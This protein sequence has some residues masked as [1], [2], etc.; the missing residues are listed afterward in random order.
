MPLA[1]WRIAT[2]PMCIRAG[3]IDMAKRSNPFERPDS[4]YL[5]AAQGWLELGLHL[6]ANAELE[7]ITPQLRTH[8]DVLDLRWQIY[9]REKQWTG[10]VDIARTL[11]RLAPRRATSW[12]HYSYSL[13]EL[14]RT[15]EALDNLLPVVN[16]FPGV[17][18]IPYN[19]ACYCSQLRRFA[20]ARQWLD[21]A[22]AIDGDAVKQTA[23]ADPDLKPLWDSLGGTLW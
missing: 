10:C 18:L 12:I 21:Q 3:A 1:G 5:R 6:E 11:T 19:L 15:E 4:I 8:P 14:K 20:E 2:I 23:I 9:A 7:N 22:V 17:W 16:R 13:H